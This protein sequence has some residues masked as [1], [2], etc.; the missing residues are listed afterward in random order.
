MVKNLAELY[1]KKENI[2][3]YKQLAVKLVDASKKEKGSINYGIY[4]TVEDECKFFL[5]EEWEDQASMIAHS[6]SD[7]F[8]E[9]F[10]KMQPFMMQPPK[11]FIC[12]E[13][14]Y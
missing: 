14:K 6:K 7:H 10:P 8:K 1:I 3:D 2:N 5:V 12:Q 13:L 11:V 9:I 4:Q